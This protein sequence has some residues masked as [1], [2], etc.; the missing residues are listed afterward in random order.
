MKILKQCEPCNQI[1]KMKYKD[2][3]FC[4]THLE[5]Y[6]QEKQRKRHRHKNFGPQRD[7][8]LTP[9]PFNIKNAGRPAPLAL[10][11]RFHS[12]NAQ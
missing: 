4:S 11:G 10:I 8:K 9:G 12:G 1:R 5:Y 2:L 6:L 3:N 7:L